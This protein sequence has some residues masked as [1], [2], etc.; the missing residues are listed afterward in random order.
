VGACLKDFAYGQL[1]HTE[2]DTSVRHCQG[3]PMVL[4]LWGPFCNGACDTVEK[5]CDNGLHS[6][7]NIYAEVQWLDCEYHLY[8]FWNLAVVEAKWRK[9]FHWNLLG[10][11]IITLML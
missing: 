5:C 1:D 11:S 9:S 2:R 6:A 3:G 4:L 8:S 10:Q 7:L